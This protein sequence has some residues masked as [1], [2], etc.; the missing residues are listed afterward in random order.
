ML[1]DREA[2][3]KVD[4]VP[5]LG[6]RKD[7]VRKSDAKVTVLRV[8]ELAERFPGQVDLL[9]EGADPKPLHG[10]DLAGCGRGDSG[11]RHLSAATGHHIGGG[12][13]DGGEISV[14]P[15]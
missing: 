4:G 14:L 10:H 7:V 3:Q 15:D 12:S 9:E 5:V 13:W 1:H 11:M 8:E 6:A 2:S